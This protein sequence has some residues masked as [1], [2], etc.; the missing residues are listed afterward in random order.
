M[1]YTLA[2]GDQATKDHFACRLEETLSKSFSAFKESKLNEAM[3]EVD[4]LL[5]KATADLQKVSMLVIPQKSSHALY[6]PLNSE[7][8]QFCNLRIRSHK[9]VSR[10]PQTIQC[11]LAVFAGHQW[12][13]NSCEFE[14]AN[15]GLCG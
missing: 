15:E 10:L 12:G 5:L 2:I 9:E 14:D 11:F 3:A 4:S 13:C 1:Y 7:D 8:W 6:T